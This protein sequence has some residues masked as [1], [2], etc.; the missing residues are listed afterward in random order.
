M[1]YVRHGQ[2]SVTENLT[3]WTRTRWRHYNLLWLLVFVLT[4]LQ[5][6]NL[7][8]VVTEKNCIRSAAVR[9]IV[10]LTNFSLFIHFGWSLASES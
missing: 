9:P 4:L 3:K 8:S 1:Y 5:M 6:I 10:T 7:P 2:V